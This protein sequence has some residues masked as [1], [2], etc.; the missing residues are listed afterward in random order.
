MSRPPA[1]RLRAG[2]DPARTRSIGA[3][4]LFIA[5]AGPAYSA[6][7]GAVGASYLVTLDGHA[8]VL[9]LGHGAYARLAGEIEPSTLDAVVISHLHPDHFVDLVALRHYLRYEFEPPRRVRAIGP[10]GLDR[11]LDDLHAQP[12]FSAESLDVAVLEPG[13]FAIGPFAMEARRITHTGDSY[14]LRVSPAGDP[15]ARGLVY[16]GDCGRGADL[17]PLIR[18]GDT[19][20]SEASFGTGPV[21]VGDMHLDGRSAGRAAAAGG[22]GRLLL[23]HILGTYDFDAVLA[24]ARDAFAGPVRIVSP[25]ER[26]EI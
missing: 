3:M 2:A 25:G 17:V 18:A 15:A 21:P 14:A 8:I 4:D 11:R 1:L 22:A 20:L 24:A 12:G 10:R 6:R 19:L 23:T 9:D 16:S 7:P 13:A 5:G 26:L